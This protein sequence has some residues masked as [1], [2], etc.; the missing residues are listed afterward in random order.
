MTEAPLNGRHTSPD[1]NQA[2]HEELLGPTQTSN[3][4]LPSQ[5]WTVA[6]LVTRHV[7]TATVTNDH[8]VI[9][10]TV[11]PVTTEELEFTGWNSQDGTKTLAVT[12]ARRQALR[13]TNAS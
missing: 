5:R 13:S 1:L 3:A 8:Y 7:S 6:T 12:A 4:A 11:A 2:L 9:V 10:T